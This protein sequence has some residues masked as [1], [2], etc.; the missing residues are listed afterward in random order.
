MSR[1]ALTWFIFGTV[2]ASAAVDFETQILP[3]FEKNCFECHSAK[4]KKPKGDVSLDTAVALAEIA[5]EFEWKEVVGLLKLPS[6]DDDLMP[7]EDKGKPLRKDDIALIEQWVQEGAKLGSFIAF[8]HRVGK[9]TSGLGQKSIATETRAA[10]AE[11][12][13]LVAAGLQQRGL[14]R[15]PEIDDAT[16]LR[17]A[18]LELAGRNPTAV[19]AAAFL[20]SKAADKRSGL[21]TQLSDSA[22]YVSRHLDYWEKVLRAQSK[23]DG[24]EQDTW[25]RYL[26]TVIA[27]NQPYD[28]WVRE[29]FTSEGRMW[30]NPAIGFYMRDTKNRLAGYEAMSAVFLGTD[31][32]CAQCHDHPL[33]PLSQLGY[34]KM[35][36]FYSASHPFN[37][38]QDRFTAMKD[39]DFVASYE[40]RNSDAREKR[41]SQRE[42]E[43]QMV[44]LGYVSS[45]DLKNKITARDETSGSRVPDSYRYDDVKHKS[46]LHPEPIFG[47]APALAKK[48]EKPMEVFAQWTTDPQNLKFTHVIANRMWLKI[49]GAPVLGPPTDI[50][51]PEASANPVLAAHLAELMLACGYDLKKFQ[52][53][54]MNTRTYQSVAV[55]AEKVGAD[56]VFQGPVM[57]RLSAE[58]I[59]DSLLTLIRV[60]IDPPVATPVPDFSF[61]RALRGAESPDRYWELVNAEI[62]LQMQDKTGY[63]GAR[64]DSIRSDVKTSRQGFDSDFLVRA[65]ELKS[66]APDGH[67]LQV[68]GQG[69]RGV[70][71]DQWDTATIP[72]ALMLLNGNL[73]DEVAKPGS[74]ISTALGDMA[75]PAATIRRIYLAALARMPDQDELALARQVTADGSRESYFTLLWILLNTTEFILQP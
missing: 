4:A 11:V 47:K 15:T 44:I 36:G 65:S 29:M 13:R 67:F 38:T 57:R 70:I 58:Q 7:P 12:D 5:S 8:T 21:I 66:P 17:R 51:V 71:E 32:G 19:E 52:A 74:A 43:M 23:Q 64:G 6:G 50:V 16:F 18:F 41:L 61:L 73:H 3:I 72:Q 49:M 63:F 46:Y 37:G 24:N 26:R 27:A 75:D 45:A 68:F 10:A 54:L 30:E 9:Q 31:I 2:A 60:D 56:F 59:W 39:R 69:R 42:R 33:K 55:P 1:F 25:L 20:E 53:I 40:K 28:Q 14:E 48:G 22:A 62:D 34:F 35:Y